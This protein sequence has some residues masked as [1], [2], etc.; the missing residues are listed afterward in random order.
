[1]QTVVI[2]SNSKADFKMITDIAKKFGA[3][4]KILKDEDKD[5]LGLLKAMME[6]RTGKYVNTEAFLKKLGK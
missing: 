3:K 2:Q 6:G 4:I 5:D 1:M